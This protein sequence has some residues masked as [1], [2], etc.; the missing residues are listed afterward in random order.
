VDDKARVAVSIFLGAIAGGVAG[1]V[2]F[3]DRGRDFRRQLEP[4]LNELMGEVNHLRA[5]FD[6]ARTAFSDGLRSFND[7]MEQDRQQASNW[8]KPESGHGA[9]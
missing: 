5:T 2:L 8:P 4:Q 9:H 3:T 7:L 1:Y 6:R